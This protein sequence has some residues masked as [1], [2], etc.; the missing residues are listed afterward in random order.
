MA[1]SAL[2]VSCYFGIGAAEAGL[3][4]EPDI[5]REME[6]CK[7]FQD[8]IL[9]VRPVRVQDAVETA[10]SIARMELG[11]TLADFDDDATNFVALVDLELGRL[12]FVHPAD[13]APVLGVGAG[14]NDLDEELAGLGL[15]DRGFEDGDREVWGLSVSGRGG[16]K[17]RWAYRV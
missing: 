10:D 9:G 8:G 1:A 7:L 3:T 4:F 11:D 5:L 13:H 2:H 6:G 17:E 16:D 12:A 15:R 14:G